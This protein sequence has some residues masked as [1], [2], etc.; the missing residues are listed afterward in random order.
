MMNIDGRDVSLHAGMVVTVE[1]RTG[2]RTASITS[3]HPFKRLHGKHTGS[4]S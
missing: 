1:V 3:S 4:G 2:T